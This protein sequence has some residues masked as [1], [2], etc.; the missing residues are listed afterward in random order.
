MDKTPIKREELDLYMPAFPRPYSCRPD[1][2][3]SGSMEGAEEGM[4]LR[5][6]FAGKALVAVIAAKKHSSI[7][8]EEEACAAYEY[9]DA[10]LAAREVGL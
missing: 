4:S 3:K 1:G 8:P 5:D 9:A 10:M 6:Y 2:Y 7:T